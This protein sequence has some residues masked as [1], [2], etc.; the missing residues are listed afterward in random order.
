MLYDHI[1]ISCHE[2]IRLHCPMK[3]QGQQAS[4]QA[5]RRQPQATQR[6]TF[7]SEFEIGTSNEQ[8]TCNC[9][10]KRALVK[11]NGKSF[12]GKLRMVASYTFYGRV[13]QLTFSKIRFS[14]ILSN[15]RKHEISE[16]R[17]SLLRSR[18]GRPTPVLGHRWSHL[19]LPK[20]SHSY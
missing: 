14:V 17:N 13:I 4:F 1:I 7:G 2:I 20:R 12:G 15:I 11:D 3:A 16:L 19:T 18:F 8:E 9:R 5:T 6:Q 10:R